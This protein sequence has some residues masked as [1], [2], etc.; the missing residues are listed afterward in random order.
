MPA[1]CS[2]N[3]CFESNLGKLRLQPK[4]SNE[5]RQH[6]KAAPGLYFVAHYAL[7]HKLIFCPVNPVCPH[8][9]NRKTK[10]PPLQTAN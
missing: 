5:R 1:P 8:F 6:C 10:H 7:L 4:E 9:T 3:T 2:P